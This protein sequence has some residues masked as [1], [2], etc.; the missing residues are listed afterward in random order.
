MINVNALQNAYLTKLNDDNVNKR[1]KGNEQWLHASRAGSCFKKSLF[2]VLDFPQASNDEATNRLFDLGN[3]IHESTQTGLEWAIN[4]Q[5]LVPGAR[6]FLE[7]ELTI[8][9]L[10]VRGFTDMFVINSPL[11]KEKVTEILDIKSMKDYSWKMKFGRTPAPYPNRFAELQLATYA[12]A[13]SLIRDNNENIYD[14]K[15]EEYYKIN[16][17]IMMNIYYYKK[18]DSATKTIRVEG[19]YVAMAIE[20]W[21][22]VNEFIANVTS[23]DDITGK[24]KVVHPE[25]AVPG[26]VNVPRYK[27]ECN[28]CNYTKFCKGNFSTKKPKAKSKPINFY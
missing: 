17:V 18:S 11:G 8:P 21:N 5:G 14:D 25:N 15:T 20:Y 10:K 2:D 16:K 19:K 12:Y 7:H 13:L 9:E 22:K 3:R 26:M 28:Y 4:N 24:L 23:K 27:W 6:I 1:Y